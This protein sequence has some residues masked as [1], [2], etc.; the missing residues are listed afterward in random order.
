MVWKIILGVFLVF[1]IGFVIAARKLYESCWKRGKHDIILGE[2]TEWQKSRVWG[3][4]LGRL[5]CKKKGKPIITQTCLIRTSK[6]KQLQGK[7]MWDV[8]SVAVGPKILMNGRPAHAGA[9]APVK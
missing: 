8:C 5:V 9:K 4:S 6:R 2:V 3:Y 7:R 1:A